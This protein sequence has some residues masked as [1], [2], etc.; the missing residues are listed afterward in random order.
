MTPFV[1]A[2]RILFACL[3]FFL[4]LTSLY[5]QENELDTL[6]NSFKEYNKLAW[7]EKIFVHTDKDFYVA[8]EIIWFKVYDTDASFHKPVRMSKV[9]YLEIMNSAQKPILQ[10]KISLRNGTGKGSLYLP[11]TMGS[12]TYQVRAYTSWMKNFSPDYCFQKNI[13]LINSLSSLDLATRKNLPAYDI[14]FFP[15]GGNLVSSL[16]SR[17][18]FKATDQYGKGIA[19]TGSVINQKNDTVARF[20]SHKFGMGHFLFT[21]LANESYTAIIKTRD[22]KTFSSSLPKVYEEGYVLSLEDTPSGRLNIRIQVSKQVSGSTTAPVFLL[23]HTRQVLKV[24]E[25]QTLR[26]GKAVFSI[27]KGRLGEGISHITVFN[28]LGQ[29]VCERLYFKRPAQKMVIDVKTDQPQYTS[30]KKVAVNVLTRDGEGNPIMADMSLSV[31]MIDSLQQ[32]HPT[33]ILS[34]LWLSSDL[35]G[36]VESPE[37]Y[38][39]Q[40]SPEV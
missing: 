2:G 22:G 35:N 11:F 21:P 17:L 7:Q 31:Y 36:Y 14:H 30:R 40:A 15:E 34:Y 1:L 4:S 24:A 8:R 37:Y 33:D 5:A 39:Q 32:P 19:C 10:A 38:L 13:T 27:E 6:V 18:A 12:G 9:A 23:G 29:P 20:Q 28:N 25:V 16:E 3:L 26:D